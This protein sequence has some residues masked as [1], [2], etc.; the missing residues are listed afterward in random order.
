MRK[1]KPWDMSRP[2]TK[3]VVDSIVHGVFVKEGTM[4]AFPTCFPGV[5]VAIPADESHI[6]AL[7]VTPDGIVYGGT[8]GRKVHL[9]VGMFHGVTGIVFDMGSVEGATE[10]K[11]ICCTEMEFIACV[12]GPE[13]GRLTVGK[14]QPLPFDLI[15]EWGFTRSPFDDLGE[16]V[17]GEKIV[18]AVM[19]PSKLNLVGI[20]PNHLFV[21]DFKH[22]SIEVVG[23]V[24]GRGRI[25]LG[26]EGGIFGVDG[27]GLW[28]FDPKG[29]GMEI[30]WLDIPEGNWQNGAVRWAK[31][32]RTGLQ[33]CTD[34]SGRL[35]SFDEKEGFSEELARTPLT[36]VG[37]MAVTLDGRL[38]GTC[39][40]GVSRLF[41]FQP[42]ERS[43]RDLGVAVSVIERRRYGYEF[44]AAAVGRDG[45]IIFGEDDDL[46]HIW[47]YFP[48]ISGR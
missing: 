33:Y 6:T 31:D 14:L 29:R 32:Q 17:P 13:G 25:A 11:E 21:A 4:I 44:G 23:E 7:D 43:M 3:E 2:E 28:R 12:N 10:C 38:F 8:S 27:D 36:P 22:R 41:Y 39:G 5:T 40:K 37:P 47:L 34:S 42:E 26:S 48:R 1:R 24:A 18:H 35:Y 45:E 16:A 46:G 15:Q 30:K 9:F 20:T 19:D